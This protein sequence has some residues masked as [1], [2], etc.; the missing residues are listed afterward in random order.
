MDTFKFQTT[1]KCGGCVATLRPFLDQEKRI[2][3]WEVD[4]AS[5]QKILTVESAFLSPDELLALI[6]KAGFQGTQL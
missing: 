3:K 1:L 6:Q 4:L 5:P 2:E